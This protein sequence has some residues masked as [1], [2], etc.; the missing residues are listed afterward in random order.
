MAASVNAVVASSGDFYRFRNYGTIVYD[1][2][3]Q[4]IRSEN[5]DT[6]LSMTRVT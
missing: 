3:V 1:G 6:V 4:R 5:V 2:Q